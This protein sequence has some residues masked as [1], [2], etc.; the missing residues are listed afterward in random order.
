MMVREMEDKGYHEIV[1]YAIMR[2]FAYEEFEKLGRFEKP[3]RQA[4]YFR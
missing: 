3:L 2:G 1:G 4:F